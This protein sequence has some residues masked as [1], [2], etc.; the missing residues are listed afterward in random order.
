MRVQWKRPGEGPILSP[1]S[2]EGRRAFKTRCRAILRGN[3]LARLYTFL[4][5]GRFIT[6]RHDR[7]SK[8]RL[9]SCIIRSDP[10]SWHK[11]ASGARRQVR[12]S[13]LADLVV[14]AIQLE[15]IAELEN[16]L[17]STYKQGDILLE[18]QGLVHDATG[19]LV[20]ICTCCEC[21][22]NLHKGELPPLALA[23]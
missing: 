11:R 10:R 4:P 17:M 3:I 7:H 5:L 14:D 18:P 20:G 16:V 2:A 6:S 19:L 1:S 8:D 9:T 23:N 13:S 15:S 22:S 21:V 12:S